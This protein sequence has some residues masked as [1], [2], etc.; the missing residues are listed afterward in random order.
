MYRYKSLIFI[1]ILLITLPLIF[2]NVHLDGNAA[3]DGYNSLQP[4]SKDGKLASKIDKN[5][6]FQLNN[7]NKVNVI[8]KY[9]T[10]S[11]V[12][13]IDVKYNFVTTNAVAGKVDKKMLKRLKNNPNVE[14]VYEDRV[15]RINLDVSVPL[16][17]ADD[18]EG[19]GYNGTGQTV[20]VID[21]G[22]DYTHSALGGCTE[23]EFTTGQC[24]KVI[25][26]YDFYNL[27]NNPIDDNGHGTHVAGIVASTDATYRGVASGTKL[28][29]MK[30]CNSGGSCS[31]SDVIAGIDWCVDN[32]E[33]YNISVITM[34]LGTTTTHDENDCEGAMDNI[35]KNATGK[36]IIMTV[37]SGNNGV[38]D[39]LNY[40]ACLPYTIAVGA[41]NDNDDIA[42]FT[43]RKIGLLDVLAPGVNICSS[44]LDGYDCF[45]GTSMAAP[46]VAGVA[47]L[48]KQYANYALNAED[49]RA[50][51][52]NYGVVVGDYKR[53]DALA[54]I[55]S[56]LNVNVTENKGSNV[57][58]SIDF[59]EDVNI[60]NVTRGIVLTNN[61]LEIDSTNFPQL[62][63]SAQI[64]FNNLSYQKNP[65]LYK[66]GQYCFDCGFISYVNNTL[67]FNVTSFSNYTSGVN[68]ELNIWD[69]NDS[70]D[71]FIGSNVLFYANYTNLSFGAIA[72]A[73]CTFNE[74]NN[75]SY[76]NG[77]FVFNTT[78]MTAGERSY[79]ISCSDDYFESL[80]AVDSVMI[81]DLDIGPYVVLNTVNNY[82]STDIMTFNWSATDILPNELD[83][84][85]IIDG[86]VN[87]SNQTSKEE[88]SLGNFSEG[89]H[90][91]NVSCSNI[92]SNT[93]YSETISFF[94]D[95][96]NPNV[97][98]NYPLNN[99]LFTNLHD[100]VLNFTLVDG[101]NFAVCNLS[102]DGSVNQTFIGS[103]LTNRNVTLAYGQHEWNVTCVD[104][105]GNLGSS[106]TYNLT[107]LF[108][109]VTDPVISEL[110]FLPP[111]VINGSNVTIRV[112]V[113]DNL[114]ISSV[115]ATS[116]LGDVILTLNE[117]YYTGVMSNTSVIGNYNVVVYAN[118]TNGNDANLSGSF[119]SN[120][121]VYLSLINFTDDNL[122]MTFEKDGL[123]TGN[124]NIS[125]GN[126]NLP[127]G[128]QDLNLKYN[129]SKITVFFKDVD[130]SSNANYSINIEEFYNLEPSGYDIR[131][132]FALDTDWNYTNATLEM[133]YSSV[134]NSISSED[135]LKIYK[136]NSYDFNLD[137]CGEWVEYSNFSV[138][139]DLNVVT[140]LLTSF[141]GYA[142]VEAEPAPVVVATTTSNTGGGGGG[143]SLKEEDIVEENETEEIVEE[144]IIEEIMD[145]VEELEEENV[146]E[147]SIPMKTKKVYIKNVLILIS[148][149]LFMVSALLYIKRKK[150][151][152]LISDKILNKN[153]KEVK[154]VK[155]K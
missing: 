152:R 123:E 108:Y 77:L 29:A 122:E 116:V 43:N 27:D 142:I 34:S 126:L 106:L 98:L 78:F 120:N 7:E 11:E 36:G 59:L 101:F 57:Y 60:T 133:D 1:I 13:D 146:K 151:E 129:Q 5:V 30:V 71:A 115:W 42:D 138:D 47:A 45:N 136:C 40:P 118:D 49:T 154:N 65:A 137:S 148:G 93:N 28:I 144:E 73:N 97:T 85:L 44:Y 99:S 113:T 141:S 128:I 15:L 155:K 8:V 55:N 105:L 76:E 62:N 25:G 83:C 4:L 9:K 39:G 111:I 84:S 52:K 35:I 31:S 145:D 121:S 112:N 131:L 38:S 50:Y 14:G 153:K 132:G 75:M 37:S 139:K 48:L 86:V 110:K 69:S 19:L 20:C 81:S 127:L 70:S 114:E 147:V 63:K 79:N 33:L 54:S 119:V 140:I 67:T 89:V 18:V 80:S 41:T 53:V 21:T 64:T 91:W 16:I 6:E 104:S 134:I 58:G 26:G 94:I 10:K 96:S 90:W 117:G 24:E 17:N 92:V 124:F 2:A 143:F 72:T 87:L 135:N 23:E 149:L 150:G 125:E 56:L 74:T 32:S 51:L 3:I 46:H 102:I 100:F 88:V 107:N 130:I 22:I 95:R 66:D 12:K 68:S 82:N 61:Y 103:G 109:D